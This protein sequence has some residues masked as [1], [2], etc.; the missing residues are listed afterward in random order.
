MDAQSE[1]VEIPVSDGTRM[2]SFVSRPAGMQGDV[3][4]VMVL[5]EAFG[6]NAH[7]KDV[8]G[9]FARLGYLAIAPDFFH[10]QGDRIDV[11]Y[12]D[13]AQAMAHA[14]LLKDNEIAADQLAAYGWLRDNGVSNLPISAVGFC[15]GGRM[16][17][18]AA[19]NLDL[20][21]AVSFYG[22]GIAGE[23]ARGGLADRA[24]FLKAPILFFWGGQD[25]HVTPEKARSVVEA[26]R[27]AGKAFTSVE[28]SDAGHGFFCDMR[29][30]FNRS[31]ATQ[32]WELTLAFMRAQHKG[33]VRTAVL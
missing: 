11:P 1:Q 19:L 17:F 28:I 6:V 16:A 25:Q 2:L 7:I 24:K 32:A 20:D 22:G 3:A 33:A 12:S 13:M 15:V 4:G 10:R 30:A 8:T 9:R 27:S 18:L 26:L 31:A 14:R 23:A 29:P 5:Q 21:S